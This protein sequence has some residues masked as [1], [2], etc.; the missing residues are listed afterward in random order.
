MNRFLLLIFAFVLCLPELR[1]QQIRPLD[2]DQYGVQVV[3]EPL[4][5]Q[6]QDG[7]L[8]FQS[9]SSNYKLWFDTRVQVDGAFFWGE[10]S[11]ADHIGNGVSIRRARLALKAQLTRCWYGEL[12]TDFANG[13]LEL[14]DALLR[15][16]GVPCTQF[17]VG[18][19][20]E[21]F[22]IS[23]NTT[24]RYL[25]LIERPMVVSALA[26]SRHIGV[27]G[28]FARNWLW[29]SA[30]WFL[31]P[32]EDAEI[33]GYVED[34]NK[35]YGRGPGHS[36]TG[37]IAFRPLYMF[38]DM[39]LSIG[40]GYSYRTPKS[41]VAPSDYGGVRIST[42][43]STSI[44]R[45]KYLDSGFIKYVDNQMLYTFEIAGHYRGLRY[46][47]AYIA[48]NIAIR[49]N[50]AT[51]AYDTSSKYFWG[52]YGQAGVLLFGGSQNYDSDGNKYTRVTRGR[53][54]GDIELCARYEYFDL[55]DRNIYGGA[56]EAVTVGVNY[57]VNNNV[58]I[59]V[60]Y[61]YNN[62]DRYA[63]GNGKYYVGR[64]AA[65]VPTKDPT[66]VADSKAGVDYSMMAMRFQ[67]NF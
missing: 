53:T 61:Q 56:A 40:I 35:D 34:N 44:N 65:G 54:W 2:Y 3:S 48:S 11:Y 57:Y 41:D 37:K 42:R 30:G 47:G 45:K 21:F 15:F 8:V 5:A 18:N 33:R 31:Q 13:V 62:N 22:S 20:K 67:V 51:A 16:D 49:K 28:K 55:N 38:D 63:N 25:M 14:K 39:S 66:V 46:E 4:D 26:P 1:A 59:M 29:A 17:Q 64:T 50:S 7:I 60:N 23:Q 24:S 10:P 36:F 52:W 32:V 12:D 19:F 27:N 9:R 58:K 43:N 6:M